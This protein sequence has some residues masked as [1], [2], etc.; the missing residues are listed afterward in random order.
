MILCA[1]LLAVTVLLAKTLG[2]GV[3]GMPLHPLQVSAGRFCFALA[4]LLPFVAWFRPAI[5]GSAWALHVGRSFCGWAGVSCMFAAA[6]AMP[7]ADATAISFLSPMITMLLAIPLLGERVG[8]WRWTAAAV[9]LG[10][11]MIIIRPGTDAFQFAA[12]IALVAALFQ[13]LEAILIKKLSVRE[14][15]LRILF[16]NNTIGAAMSATAAAFVWVTPGPAQWGMLAVLGATMVTAQSM[17][18]LALRRT[19]ASYA[20]PFFY[21]TLLFAGIYDFALFGDAPDGIS[22]GGMVLVVAGALVLAWREGFR[23]R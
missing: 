23:R 5:R 14:D 17:F 12:V 20:I 21:A 13:G 9:A 2:R 10:G 7:L 8:P 6:A 22:I 19:D 1:A 15:P 3:E 16:I 11:G 4:T 18:I